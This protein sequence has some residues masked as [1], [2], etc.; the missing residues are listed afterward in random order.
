[1]TRMS[2][3]LTR[4][5]VARFLL[6]LAT[7]FIAVALITFG[8]ALADP[9]PGLSPLPVAGRIPPVL[10]ALPM[11]LEPLMPYVILGSALWTYARLARTQELVVART[12]GVSS[13]QFLTPP[14]I[15]AAGLSLF[16]LA[17][18]DP[19]A[20][21]LSF[22]AHGDRALATPAAAGQ[23][24]VTPNGLW[25]RQATA[26][27]SRLIIHAGRIAQQEPHLELEDVI[28]FNFGAGPLGMSRIDARRAR[29]LDG[30]WL[31]NQVILSSPKD[32][33]RF[34]DT[35]LLPSQLTP[36]QFS[37]VSPPETFSVWALPRFIDT[38]EDVGLSAS[39]YKV[40]LHLLLAGPA[41]LCAMILIAAGLALRRAG[42]QSGLKL[43]LGGA[44]AAALLHGLTDASVS[45]GQA[46]VIPPILASWSPA[47][48]AAAGGYAL[49]HGMEGTAS[50]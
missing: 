27:R 17:V 42:G 2:S 34:R 49:V 50:S 47:V 3:T 41:L 29:L 35:Y 48:L 24:T 22:R 20:A 26:G 12:T 1:M 7:V 32:G 14:L 9:L 25:F 23:L 31:L 15:L 40:R 38:L 30:Y 45:L 21:A 4:Y 37:G 6:D 5:L 43:A 16:I 44:V 11:M 46:G 36:D 8:L 18:Y 19:L 13:W 39:R 28:L 10:L 33:S